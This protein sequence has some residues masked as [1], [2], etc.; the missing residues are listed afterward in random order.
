MQLS[1]A[2]LERLSATIQSLYSATHVDGLN[3]RLVEDVAKLIPCDF[4]GMALVPAKGPMRVHHNGKHLHKVLADRL[5]ALR[6]YLHQHPYEKAGEASACWGARSISDFLTRGQLRRTD[7]YNEFY[8]HVETEYQMG[9][10][11]ERVA[12]FRVGVSCNAKTKDFSVRDREILTTLSPHIVQAYKNAFAVEHIRKAASS[13]EAAAEAHRYGFIRINRNGTVIDITSLAGSLLKK[14]FNHP[15]STR[16]TLPGAVQ[17]WLAAKSP[18]ETIASTR[19]SL[20]IATGA[21]KLIVRKA[22]EG[23]HVILLL[24]EQQVGSKSADLSSLG[25]RPREAEILFWMCQGKSNPE[26]A[27][28]LGLSVRTIHKHNENI[29][30]K[31][32]VENRHAATLRAAP[33]LRDVTSL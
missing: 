3:A 9:I 19:P 22:V 18:D 28:I 20:T 27:T 23:D 6:K 17:A 30:R 5:W 25:L 10:Y 14:Y 26:I 24:T 15:V 8:R 32:G 12:G 2:D 1:R 7:L 16:R 33:L 21:T 11:T 4:A 31:L 29:F 13:F